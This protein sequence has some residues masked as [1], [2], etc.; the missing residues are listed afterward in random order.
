MQ[1][2]K[3]VLFIMLFTMAQ[4]AQAEFR[5]M[6][7]EEIKER[8]GSEINDITDSR[9]Y[10]A[11]RVIAVGVR[12]MGDKFKF[13]GSLKV[14]ITWVTDRTSYQCHN[15]YEMQQDEIKDFTHRSIMLKKCQ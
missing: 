13:V 6:S 8:G 14:K 10:W 3:P 1:F 11:G 2:I 12:D 9:G 5:W 7:I 15:I 4:V